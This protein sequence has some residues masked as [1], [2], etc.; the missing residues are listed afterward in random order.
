MD[1]RKFARKGLS[2]ATGAGKGSFL[3][4]IKEDR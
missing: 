2:Q 3:G 1:A 4:S